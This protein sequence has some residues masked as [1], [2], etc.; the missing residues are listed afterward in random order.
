M[1]EQRYWAL[2]LMFYE[3]SLFM[4]ALWSS[5]ILYNLIDESVGVGVNLLSGHVT[6]K[7]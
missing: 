6:Q 7:L 5:S 3:R 4:T 1:E 2:Y